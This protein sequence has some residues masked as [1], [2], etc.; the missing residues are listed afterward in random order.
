MG[1]N[2]GIKIPRDS[3]WAC[4][5]GTQGEG[6]PGAREVGVT[7]R[8]LVEKLQA[9]QSRNNSWVCVGLDPVLERMPGP[10]LSYDD[11]FLPFLKA[12]VDATAD[13][14]CA[15]KPNLGFFLA[16]GASGVIALERIVAYIPD[17][18]PVI[19]D[20]K[21]NDIGHTAAAYAQGAFDALGVDAV[22]VNPFLGEDGVAP[23]LARADKGAF[24]LARTSNKSARDFQD[25]HVVDPDSRAESGTGRLE[26]GGQGNGGLTLFEAVAQK[27]VLWGSRYPGSCGLVVGAT[28]P[29]E[30]AMVRDLA[31]DLPF[32][33]PGI[34]AQGGDL[35]AAVRFGPAASGVGPVIN[36][37]RG[38]LYASA[39]EDFAEAAR[40]I[41]AQLGEQ[42][43]AARG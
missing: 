8:S 4:V 20:A 21:H 26:N 3:G 18:I 42:I 16:M 38:V 7:M 25:L 30:L 27:A 41:T 37:S 33:I 29:Q 12:I 22:T 10:M 43:N 9:A 17:E 1:Q 35:E 15:F 32:L 31:P 24:V 28:Y 36:T 5:S 13:L 11:P 34:G 19:L 40:R 6:F 39:R 14:V 2:A 23:F